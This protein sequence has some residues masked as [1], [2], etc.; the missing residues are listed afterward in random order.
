MGASGLWLT[1]QAEFLALVLVV[2]YVGA[3]MVLF[4]FVVMMLDVETES[5]RKKYMSYWVIAFLAAPNTI[6]PSLLCNRFA[7][8]QFAKC[9]Y[10]QNALTRLW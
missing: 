2:V 3:V 4:L 6:W 1:M 5:T 10:A 8:I 7:I 9:S